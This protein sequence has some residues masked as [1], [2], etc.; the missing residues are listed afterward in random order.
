M[1]KK[2]SKRNVRLIRQ[3]HNQGVTGW[4]AKQVSKRRGHRTKHVKYS[5][6]GMHK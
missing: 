2:R 6:Q 5:Y 4:A 1:R 3:L